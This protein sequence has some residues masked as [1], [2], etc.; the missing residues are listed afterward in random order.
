[1]GKAERIELRL[2][3]D[4][5]S[6]LTAAALTKHTTVSEFLLSHGI[7]AAER[8]VSDPRVFIASADD[9]E[10]IQHAMLDRDPS[11]NIDKIIARFKKKKEM[12]S[13]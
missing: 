1:M 12:L 6:L 11:P 8:V 2:S 9:W 5:K 4:A 13:L 7:E 3:K 10:K